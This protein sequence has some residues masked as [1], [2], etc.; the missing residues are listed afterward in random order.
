MSEP[1]AGLT[2]SASKP[3]HCSCKEQQPRAAPCQHRLKSSTQRLPGRHLTRAW[4]GPLPGGCQLLPALF[5]EQV[6]DLLHCWSRRKL[7]E[8][9]ACRNTQAQ[10]LPLLVPGVRD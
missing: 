9:Q 1:E 7:K 2:A 6:Q 3:A 10:R 4:N 8:L 5:Q